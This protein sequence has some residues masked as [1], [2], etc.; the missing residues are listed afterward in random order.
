MRNDAIQGWTKKLPYDSWRK[1]KVLIT[2]DFDFVQAVLL[3]DHSVFISKPSL[4]G[5]L[6]VKLLGNQNSCRLSL[7]QSPRGK[8]NR[9]VLT[10]IILDKRLGKN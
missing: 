5:N 7:Q 4:L 3:L 9:R 8:T 10:G 6:S 1:T 2:G